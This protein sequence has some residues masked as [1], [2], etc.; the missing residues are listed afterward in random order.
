MNYALPTSIEDHLSSIHRAPL[1]TVE[2]S[3]AQNMLGP[4]R[5]A[6]QNPYNHSSDDRR[7]LCRELHLEIQQAK[8]MA[9]M[10]YPP[11]VG[12]MQDS[13]F[14]WACFKKI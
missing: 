7:S 14:Y 10:V 3:T 8:Q 11:S 12:F 4:L 2:P 6:I 9:R 5:N 13:Y 1:R